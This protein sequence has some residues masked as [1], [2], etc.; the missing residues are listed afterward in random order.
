MDNFS[1]QD[2]RTIVENPDLYS[3]EELEMLANKL[4]WVTPVDIIMPPHQYVDE[5][6]LQSEGDRQAFALVKYACAKHSAGWNNYYKEFIIYYSYVSFSNGSRNTRVAALHQS[7]FLSLL[8]FAF[9][10]T[11][12]RFL[13]SFPCQPLELGATRR[14]G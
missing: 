11:R 12:D 9:E 4:P 1:N 7:L 8:R 13:Y 3:L 14:E 10:R 6:K 5:R 2:G